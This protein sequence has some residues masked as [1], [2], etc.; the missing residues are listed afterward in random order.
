[1]K[2]L[3]TIFLT[4]AIETLRLFIVPIDVPLF[5]VGMSII[6]AIQGDFVLLRGI[7]WI[8]FVAWMVVSLFE[9]RKEE[10]K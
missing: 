2:K 1:M 8:F 6:M 4:G 10:N 5:A 9:A 7:L 3:G